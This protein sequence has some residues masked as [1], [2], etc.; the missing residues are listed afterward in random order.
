MRHDTLISNR[1]R[2]LRKG[3]S[4]PEVLLWTRL[5]GRRS[6]DR[7]RFRRQH[8]MGRFILD[9]YC[10]AAALAVEID[11][12]THWEDDVLARD[13]ACDA[14]LEAQGV[15]TLR[16]PASRVYADL[17]GAVDAMLLR[18]DELIRVRRCG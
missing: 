17:D 13:A 7:P 3:M 8:P 10:H 5:R 11:G 1:A 15:S 6:P 9:F 14:Y 4:E 18:A 2:A 16:I 12:S